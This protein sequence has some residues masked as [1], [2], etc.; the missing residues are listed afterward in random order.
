MNENEYKK[1]IEKTRAKIAISNFKKKEIESMAK[2]N[3]NIFSKCIAA[4]FIILSLTGVA[5][6][7]SISNKIYENFFD[8]GKGTETAINNGYIE[9]IEMQNEVS[10][11]ILEN[12][13]TGKVIEDTNT[14]IKVDELIMD[15]F[16]LSLILEVTLSDKIQEIIPAKNIWEMNFP[17]LIIYDEDYN[18][19]LSGIGAS[20]DDFCKTHNLDYD[21]I[22]DPDGKNMGSGINQYIQSRSENSVKI[23][24]NIY[25]GGTRIYPKSKELYF[26]ISEIRISDKEE[27]LVGDEEIYLKGDWDF[28]V[29]VP[30]K[31]YNRSSINYVQVSTTNLKFNVTAA[32]LLDTGMNIRL[33]MKDQKQPKRELS[34]EIEFYNSLPEDDE[35][36]NIDILNYFSNKEWQSKEY[37]EFMENHVRV[38]DFEKYLITE[39]GKRFEL[40][41]GPRENGG[42]SIDEEN[43]LHFEG[44]FDLTKYDASNTVIMHV[45]DAAGDTGEITLRRV[46]E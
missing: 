26:D 38:F 16:S 22:L 25:T 34:P 39:D 18:I 23:I 43:V 21:Y 30:E 24:N 40:T 17:D 12:E 15:D 41:V 11:T 13:E 5:F 29:D 9:E 44:M 37:Q 28:K 7:D 45:K 42:S 19:L 31:M 14:S 20:Y 36:K 10:S 2:N 33:D 6:A 32:T 1:I 35:L 46:E 4:C 3:I 8:T 27:T